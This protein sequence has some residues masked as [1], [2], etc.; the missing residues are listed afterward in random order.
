MSRVSHVIAGLLLL[1]AA[2]DSSTAADIP[3]DPQLS[4]EVDTA[5]EECLRDRGVDA[6]VDSVVSVRRNL[7]DW[8]VNATSDLDVITACE[9][10]VIKQLELFQVPPEDEEGLP[11]PDSKSPEA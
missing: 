8:E 5:W 11:R 4:A 7:R 10:E 9:F 2:C 3:V 1:S 6:Q